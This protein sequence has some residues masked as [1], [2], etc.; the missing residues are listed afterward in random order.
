MPGKVERQS[1]GIKKP[2]PN[3][4]PIFTIK[5]DDDE[6]DDEVDEVYEVDEVNYVFRSYND[7]CVCKKCGK[8]DVLSIPRKKKTNIRIS[9][10][11]RARKQSV[12]RI[13]L[14]RTQRDASKLSPRKYN[15]N[16]SIFNRKCVYYV[17]CVIRRYSV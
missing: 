1:S 12:R 3:P 14:L 10:H 17:F 6:Y 2:K 15:Q 7:N 16:K 13:S 5:V 11:R 8:N 9:S 4:K